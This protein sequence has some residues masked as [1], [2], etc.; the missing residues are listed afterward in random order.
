MLM[1]IDTNINNYYLNKI[2]CTGC[3]ENQPNQL[4]H[5]YQGGCLSTDEYM[6]DIESNGSEYSN[7]MNISYLENLMET[8]NPFNSEPAPDLNQPILT[9]AIPY[10]LNYNS[11]NN[12]DSNDSMEINDDIE[13]NNNEDVDM[14]INNNVDMDMELNYNN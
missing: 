4:A 5:M 2:T 9:L 12:L 1:S 13:S 6:A 14:E 3:L 8:V 11:N 10:K 7:D